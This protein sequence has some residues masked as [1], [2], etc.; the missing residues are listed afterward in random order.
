M[1]NGQGDASGHDWRADACAWSLSALVLGA[2]SREGLDVCAK[3]E[4]VG[5]DDAVSVEEGPGGHATWAEGGH[6]LGRLVQ[7]T[8][9][10][11]VDQVCWVA[12]RA[13]ERAL[14]ADGRHHGDAPAR[15]L[16]DLVDEGAVQEVVATVG[17]VDHI[18]VVLE[19]EVEGIKEPRRLRLVVASEYLE[20]V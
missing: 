18:D 2:C 4:E 15:Q 5:L 16:V 17:E 13:H 6:I 20:D 3:S 19:H 7:A 8:D 12:Q 11:H 1:G 14:V 10:H 9:A